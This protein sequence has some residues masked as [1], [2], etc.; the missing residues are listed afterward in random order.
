MGIDW[1]QSTTPLVLCKNF[2]RLKK[3]FLNACEKG[4]RGMTMYL[5]LLKCL[6]KPR[7]LVISS[8]KIISNNLA[9]EKCGLKTKYLDILSQG[10][11]Q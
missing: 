9:C 3:N 1:P 4:T 8:E 6:T 5:I 2:S 11:T 7:F 10:K